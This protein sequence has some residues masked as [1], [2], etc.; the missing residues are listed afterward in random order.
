[1]PMDGGF[2]PEEGWMVCAD[3]NQSFWVICPGCQKTQQWEQPLQ[4][5]AYIPKAAEHSARTKKKSANIGVIACI[6]VTSFLLVSFIGHFMGLFTLPFM[7]N[8]T[9]TP[10]GATPSGYTSTPSASTP[11]PSAGNNQ[12][13]GSG[14]SNTGDLPD[15]TDPGFFIY[16]YDEELGGIIITG[17][18]RLL[19]RTRIPEMIDGHPVVAIG[20][21]SLKSANL[22]EIYI[23]A[24]V[25]S[26]GDNALGGVNLNKVVF[27][28]DASVTEI[29][30][31]AFEGSTKLLTIII[32][33]SVTV[34]KYSAFYHSGLTSVTLGSG[35]TKIEGFAF[36]CD[37]LQSVTVPAA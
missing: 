3:C 28:P 6:L 23:P 20:N 21:A 2:V 18:T 15:E 5:N 33:D 9:D 8:G 35:L 34:I 36:R 4:Q 12:P 30:R 31:G 26:I 27:L 19:A 22:H 1:M 25:K 7:P 10:S 16:N 32:P 17:N 14:G 37:N 11:T 29:G 13:S 24:T